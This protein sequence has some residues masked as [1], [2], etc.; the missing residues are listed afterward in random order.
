[1]PSF[2]PLP[3]MTA[4]LFALLLPFSTFAEGG[5]FPSP[6]AVDMAAPQVQTKT[7]ESGQLE[8]KSGGHTY[9]LDAPT[10]KENYEAL[11]EDDKK[12]FEE[13]RRNF[14]TQ[15]L[16]ALSVLKYG[17]GMGSLVKDRISYINQSRKEA[18]LERKFEA[19]PATAQA[20]ALAALERSQEERLRMAEE[21]F[22]RSM[23]TRSQD[24]VQAILRSVDG[25]LW[26]QAPLFTRANEFGFI[27]SGGV[28]ALGGIQDKGGWGGLF[29]LG[30]S[31]G[32][33][34]ESKALAIQIF[35]DLERFEST[36]MKAVFVAGALAKAGFYMAN[37]RSGE[38]ARKGHSFY[39]PMV[40]GFTSSTPS[41]FETGLSSGLTWP[42]SPVGDLLTYTNAL[43][44]KVALRFTISPM[45][46]GF[47]RI[48]TGF[49]R[50]SLKLFL[51]PI[52][53]IMNLIKAKKAGAMSCHA[54]FN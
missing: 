35:R 47:V 6:P 39:P 2:R 54:V 37:Q 44:S 20:D 50:S 5:D 49:D 46:K 45:L 26:N 9:I 48:E 38:L 43:D 1:M 10:E 36:K 40:P 24:A 16:K 7:L 41:L 29:D 52:D 8:I 14:M 28:V 11:S 32:Y 22:A 23:K 34:R 15:L 21:S 53:S 25:Q 51:H 18:G 30:I 27:L 3:L 17:F 13:N 12:I 42:P 31:I 4:A 19:L 33:N